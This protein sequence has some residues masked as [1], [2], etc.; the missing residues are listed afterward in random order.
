MIRARQRVTRWVYDTMVRQQFECDL[1]ASPDSVLGFIV[2]TARQF[3][4]NNVL[5][6]VSRKKLTLRRLLAGATA[7]AEQ[8]P[9]RLSAEAGEHVGVLLPN[10]NAVPATLL[11]LWSRF[12]KVPA[13]F[14][15]STGIPTMLACAK[16]ADVKNII[17]SKLF[18]ER[19]KLNLQ[20]MIDAG[21]NIIYLEDVRA[22]ISKSQQWRALLRATLSPHSLVGNQE[23]A[24]PR[25]SS[26]SRAVPK[27]RPKASN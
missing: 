18:L 11:S 3:P 19:A 7:L 13:I 25:R 9:A 17:T 24:N 16:L 1:A 4:A 15:F 14:N 2:E 22:A 6:D 26:F 20:P 10:S 5:Q 8:W 12:P 27:A 21:V 23:S